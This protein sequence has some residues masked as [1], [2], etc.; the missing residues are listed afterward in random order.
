MFQDD[1][2][3]LPQT[4]DA[5]SASS[6]AARLLRV[7]SYNIR[8]DC[9][10]D[11]DSFPAIFWTNNDPFPWD[12]RVDRV[13]YTIAGLN[14]DVLGIQESKHWQVNALSCKLNYS[15]MGIG[16]ESPAGNVELLSAAIFSIIAC[17]ALLL[18]LLLYPFPRR[19]KRVSALLF[20]PL[21]GAFHFYLAF[22]TFYP[23]LSDIKTCA[24]HLTSFRGGII[25]FSVV[26]ATQGALTAMLVYRRQSARDA[27]MHLLITSLLSYL[28]ATSF[29]VPWI[30]SDEYSPLLFN[31]A[32]VSYLG[33]YNTTW[34]S[35]SQEP[36]KVASEWNAGC[37]RVATF[38]T[39]EKNGNK[40]NFINTHL[41]HVGDSARLGGAQVITRDIVQKVLPDHPVVLTGDFNTYAG[42]PCW[43]E[44]NTTLADTHFLSERVHEGPM[45]SF[46]A[47]AGEVQCGRSIDWIFVSRDR[48]HVASHKSWFLENQVSDHNPM[49]VDM[50]F[51]TEERE[52]EGA[53]AW[54]GDAD[55][56]TEDYRRPFSDCKR[57]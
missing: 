22:F 48:F 26:I 2:Q 7:L 31:P 40:F 50:Y 11:P 37:T 8:F 44:L 49:L 36:G 12:S 17:F 51:T 21:Y 43:Y 56:Q 38:G 1:S 39:F 9:Q 24:R 18:T 41:D 55:K 52:G 10:C 14:V 13:A 25:F 34:L 3:D 54:G 19:L 32:S 46:N 29:A 35:E 42:S 23:T 45:K 33:N 16:R 28:L 27:V 6:Q 4:C 57:R 30:H 53:C 5:S 20:Y 15:W 47:F